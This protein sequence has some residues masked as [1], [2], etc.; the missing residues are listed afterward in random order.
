MAQRTSIGISTQGHIVSLWPLVS[1]ASNELSVM[2]NEAAIH[3][4]LP[5]LES[6]CCT[7][8]DG[9]LPALV[10]HYLGLPVLGRWMDFQAVRSRN[11]HVI[12]KRWSGDALVK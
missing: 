1:L 7:R 8:A 3:P 2:K 5:G 6:A 11:G 10:L 9:R 12:L 4:C